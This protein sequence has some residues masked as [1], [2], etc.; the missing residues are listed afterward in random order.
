MEYSIVDLEKE[1]VS[2]LDG[3]KPDTW[4]SIVEIHD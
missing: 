2:F 1:D 4:S 3:I